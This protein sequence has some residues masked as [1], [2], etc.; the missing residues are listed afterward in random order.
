MSTSVSKSLPVRPPYDPEL[1]VGLT[2]LPADI[3]GTE[4]GPSSIEESRALMASWRPSVESLTRG[5]A[6]H[7]DERKV[8]GPQGSPDITLLIMSPTQ[9]D[10]PWP[11]IYHI[12]GGAMVAGDHYYGAQSFA[13][14][15]G[16]LK[17]VVVSVEYRLAPENPHPAPV[18]DCYAGLEW[19]A[20][21]TEAL[22]IDPRRIVIMGGSAGSALAASTALLS[23]DRNGPSVSHQILGCPMLDDRMTGPSTYATDLHSRNMRKTLQD[24]WAALLGD[25]AAG[26]DVSPYASPARAEDLSGLPPTYIDIG[27]SEVLLSEAV[28]YAT[29]LSYAGVQ[30]E[31]HVWPGAFHGFNSLVPH[32]AVSRTANETR[33]AYLRRV[34]L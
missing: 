25:A 9:G 31:L 28:D 3:F 27:S 11:V 13:D 30:V 29:R 14:L 4:D 17:V 2:S 22:K 26:P 5:G 15:V 8:P 12:H 16:E 21:N 6:V 34:L 1:E 33:L 20:R 32:A 10:G 23:R 19:V 18:E 7:V 24:G